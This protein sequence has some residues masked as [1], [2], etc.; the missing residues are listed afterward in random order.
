MHRF[1]RDELAARTS[2][3]FADTI[4]RQ[5]VAQETVREVTLYRE[6]MDEDTLVVD[7]LTGWAGKAHA[8]WTYRYTDGH[9]GHSVINWRDVERYQEAI[10][11]AG[12]RQP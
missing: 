3:E 1:D 10:L 12:R 4:Q 11:V 2:P 5:L 8:L 9:Y 7:I 6:Q